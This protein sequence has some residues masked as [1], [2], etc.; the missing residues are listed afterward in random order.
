LPS[1]SGRECGSDGCGGSCGTCP[2]HSSC[3]G[4]GQCVC[5]DGYYPNND[6]TQC[7][8]YGGPCFGVTENGHCVGDIW[9]FCQ[10]VYLGSGIPPLER[11]EAID[12]PSNFGSVCSSIGGLEGSCECGGSPGYCGTSG[13]AIGDY[14]VWFSCIG[15]TNLAHY[16]CPY[17]VGSFFAFCSFWLTMFGGGWGCMSSECG[18]LWDPGTDTLVDWCPGLS[19]CS[20]DPVAN[21]HAC[22]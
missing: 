21:T 12:C 13:A 7:V 22:Y 17:E 14:D 8:A 15:G 11:V 10:T 9:V 1:C 18:D 5:E 4:T 20:Y 16:D 6:F 3:D 19:D 2:A